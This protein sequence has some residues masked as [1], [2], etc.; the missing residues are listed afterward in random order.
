MT[1][2][3]SPT[4][5]DPQLAGAQA[6]VRAFWS[7]VDA[8]GADPKRSLDELTS[9]ARGQTLETWRELLTQRRRQA[10]RQV[11]RTSIVSSEASRSGGKVT[12]DTCI[13]VSKTSLVDEDGKSVVAVNRAPRVR[14]TSVVE[15]GTNGKYYVV[16]DTA[17]ETC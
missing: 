10:H 11:G 17:V 1:S 12:V 14:Y 9:V 16:Q 4:E 5:T 13:D 7:R 6:V 8:L 2:S 3:S 15:R